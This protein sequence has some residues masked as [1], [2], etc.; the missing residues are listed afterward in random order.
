MI[1][2]FVGGKHGRVEQV[3]LEDVPIEQHAPL[4]KAY[5]QIAPGARPYIA[6]AKDAPL[7]EFEQAAADIFGLGYLIRIKRDDSNF[8]PNSH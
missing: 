6:V 3:L 2:I 1:A 8:H 5:L 7:A 4:L